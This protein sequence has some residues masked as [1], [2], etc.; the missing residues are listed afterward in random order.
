M[1][2]HKS[3]QSIFARKREIFDH[4]INI[5]KLIVNKFLS[6]IDISI[7]TNAFGFSYSRSGWHPITGLLT[8]IY[9]NEND[10]KLFYK[11]FEN[12][13]PKFSGHLPQLCGVEVDY[14]P[15]IGIYPWGGFSAKTFVN[16][17]EALKKTSWLTGPLSQDHILININRTKQAYESIK[18]F[19]Y[20][21]WL[22]VNSFIQGVLL[23]KGDGKKR[24]VV[25]HGKHRVGILSFLGYTEFLAQ[26]E[27]GMENPIREDQF[28]TWC[29]VKNGICSEEDALSYFNS[30][31]TLNGVERAEKYGL[32]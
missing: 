32:L 2:N 1:T 10:P 14:S 29:N 20:R 31:F 8:E 25:T 12:Y 15:A 3:L 6:K 27:P 5:P 22:P 23:E 4:C 7:C 26:F 24:F 13:Q 28:K 21:P 18:R 11:Y 17:G 16:G 30:F 9:D 19:G